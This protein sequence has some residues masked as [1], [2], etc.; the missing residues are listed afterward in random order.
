MDKR[1]ILDFIRANPMATMCTVEGNKPHGRGMETFRVDENGLIFYTGT[2]KDVYR[3]LENNPEVELCYIKDI[4]VRVSGRI[5]LLDDPELKKEIVAKRPF[6]KGLIE[7]RGYEA[8]GVMRLKGGR[9]TTWSMKD[10]A[11]PKT[12]VDL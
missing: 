11:A 12:Y 2:Y 5:E 7:Q 4:Q 6:L 10:M 9:A 3:Q 1:E 8:I